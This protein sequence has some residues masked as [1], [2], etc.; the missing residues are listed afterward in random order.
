MKRISIAWFLG[1]L[2]ICITV[3]VGILFR[4]NMKDCGIAGLKH[5]EDIPSGIML[6]YAFGANGNESSGITEMTLQ[7]LENA[8][9]IAVVSPT[10]N[11]EVAGN[12]G[13]QEF[14]IDRVIKG[15]ELVSEG[16]V[17]YVHQAYFFGVL[18]NFSAYYR[19]AINVMWPEYDYLVFLKESPL[20]EYQNRDV[21][22]I[23]SSLLGCVR[24]DHSQTETLDE[25][26]QS[27]DFLELK[28]Y[29]FFSVSEKITEEQNKVREELR[30]KYL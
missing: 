4:I 7:E 15:E 14:T 8:P 10:G 25:D 17:G 2:M 19:E 27:Y 24:T 30:E 11:I 5:V 21:F 26:Y 13:L 16:D 28:E 29:E 18:S 6:E 9:I 22:F 12:V 23:V 20:N 3:V 1:A